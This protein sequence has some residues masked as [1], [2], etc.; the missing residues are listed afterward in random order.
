M[1]HLLHYAKCFI[2][3]LLCTK[4]P[5]FTRKA[6]VCVL[7]LENAEFKIRYL[8]RAVSSNIGR[9]K[10]GQQLQN[11]PYAKDK[12]KVS[13]ITWL[14]SFSV[15][16]NLKL[17]TRLFEPPTQTSLFVHPVLIYWSSE[18]L[19]MGGCTCVTNFMVSMTKAAIYRHLYVWDKILCRK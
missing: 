6:N 15:C 16:T 13:N 14:H 17:C 2:S 11:F 8:V 4:S 19:Y 7:K 1:Q 9:S 5:H 10:H 3:A 18:R 12:Q